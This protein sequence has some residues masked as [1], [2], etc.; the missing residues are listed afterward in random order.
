M[1]VTL[2]LALLAVVFSPAAAESNSERDARMA[3]WREARFGMFVHWGLYAIPAGEWDG[4]K[5]GSGGEWI[6]NAGHI[7][8]ADYEKLRTQFNPTKFDAKAWVRAA[9]SLDGDQV[10]GGGFIVRRAE[11][12]AGPPAGAAGRLD[13]VEVGDH[14]IGH[15]VD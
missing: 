1:K 14:V 12:A 5:I 11:R 2:V 13:G 9:V 3:W 6:L 4:K 15:G 10:H 8:L 7:P